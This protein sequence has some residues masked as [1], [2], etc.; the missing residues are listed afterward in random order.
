MKPKVIIGSGNI[1][2]VQRYERTDPFKNIPFAEPADNFVESAIFGAIS[3]VAALGLL[4]VA[5][6]YTI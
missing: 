6:L 5:Y 4:A 3:C 2:R 1:L